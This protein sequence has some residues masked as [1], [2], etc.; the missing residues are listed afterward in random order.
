MPMN[1]SDV[2]NY[3][4]VIECAERNSKVRRLMPD[5]DIAE[6]T[7]RSIGGDA[8]NFYFATGDDDVTTVFLRVTLVS[9]FE[10]AWRL[11][12]L[13]AQYAIGEFCKD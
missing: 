11:S 6:G 7:A 12:E 13:A 8:P 2:M 3:A 1:T 9:G 5:G 10:T 4:Y